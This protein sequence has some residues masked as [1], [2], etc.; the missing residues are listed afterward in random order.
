MP[1]LSSERF[2]QVAPSSKESGQQE[3]KM[4]ALALLITPTAQSGKRRD[5]TRCRIKLAKK[6]AVP[7]FLAE[8]GRLLSVLEQKTVY[9]GSTRNVSTRYDFGQFGKT[10]RSGKPQARCAICATVLPGLGQVS[11]AVFQKANLGF[12]HLTKQGFSRR[13]KNPPRITRED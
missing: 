13:R 9:I 2:S 5:F 6:K 11:L 7:H 3:G 12:C 1:G 8:E 4:T 10:E